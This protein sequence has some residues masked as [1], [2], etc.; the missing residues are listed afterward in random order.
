MKVIKKFTFDAAHFLP[1]YVGKCKQLHGHTYHLEVIVDGIL[2]PDT[3][4]VIDF[5][6]LKHIVVSKALDYL[7]HRLLNDVI[8]NPTAENIVLWIRDRIIKD[9]E[10]TITL[11]LWETPDSYV[12][13]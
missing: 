13:L 3:G 4:M 12:E 6:Q 10:G 2:N 11:R 5:S 7:D 9:I 1:Q 8:E